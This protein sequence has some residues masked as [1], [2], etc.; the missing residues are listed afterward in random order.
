MNALVVFLIVFFIACILIAVLWKFIIP[1]AA[2]LTLN[3]G[4]ENLK[5]PV[6]C[7]LKTVLQLLITLFFSLLPVIV[8]SLSRGSNSISWVQLLLSDLK[9]NH[10]F[11]YAP[12][13]LAQFFILTLTYDLNKNSRSTMNVIYKIVLVLSFYSCATGCLVYTGV[14][15]RTVF[16][17]GESD[18]SLP[19]NI[20]L[21]IICS[22]LISWYYCTYKVTYNPNSPIKSYQKQHESNRQKFD[23]VIRN[24]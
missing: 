15:D 20:D 12:A 16:N 3:D 7:H 14:I 13:F 24:A 19:S 22:T 2:K 6:Q 5:P 9:E 1:E 18:I 21:T 8:L 17:F 4:Y 10:V 23:E 11:I